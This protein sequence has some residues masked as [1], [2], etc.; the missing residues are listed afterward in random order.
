MIDFSMCRRAMGWAV[1]AA[2][3]IPYYERSNPGIVA[4]ARRTLQNVIADLRGPTR[5]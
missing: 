1:R 3:A 5:G 4:R 2:Y